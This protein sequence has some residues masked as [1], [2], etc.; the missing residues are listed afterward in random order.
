M[1]I[2]KAF[3][4]FEDAGILESRRLIVTDVICGSLGI[5]V[6]FD[7]TFQTGS[8]EHLSQNEM[9]EISFKNSK[10]VVAS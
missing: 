3:I 7:V 10:E 8:F 6:T 4:P 5:I 2:L 1:D 9:D